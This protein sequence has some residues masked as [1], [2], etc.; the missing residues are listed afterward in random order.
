MA[1]LLTM[2]ASS[3]CCTRLHTAARVTQA[4]PWLQLSVLACEQLVDLLHMML[5][6]NFEH[7]L[8]EAATC[9]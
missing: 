5:C 3:R 9:H 1:L 2:L 8:P 7:I 6:P 4:L